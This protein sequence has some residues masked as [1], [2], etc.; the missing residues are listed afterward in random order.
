MKNTWKQKTTKDGLS[1]VLMKAA[2][3]CHFSCWKMQK[4]QKKNKHSINGKWFFVY[5]SNVCETK[6]RRGIFDL[7]SSSFR[8]WNVFSWAIWRVVGVWF[9]SVWSLLVKLLHIFC[10][11]LKAL[12]IF[13]SF[14]IFSKLCTFF[15]NFELLMIWVL[16][17]SF[18]SN[19]ELFWYLSKASSSFE[20]FFKFFLH[21]FKTLC[22]LKTLSFFDIWVFGKKCFLKKHWTFL[23]N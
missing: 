5:V 21:F 4:K 1:M 19:S 2:A 7:H 10:A 8:W 13:Q 12:C 18:Q 3:A 20:L 14:L 6:S 16:N 22:F 15:Q 9:L 11:F 23:W 17:V